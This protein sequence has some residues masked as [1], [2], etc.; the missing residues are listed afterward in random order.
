IWTLSELRRV[1]TRQAARERGLIRYYTGEPC[2]HG[3]VVER[4]VAEPGNCVECGRI[5]NQR[6]RPVRQRY[7]RTP[8][9]KATEFRRSQSPLGRAR[10]A[11]IAHYPKG[12]MSRFRKADHCAAQR[13]ARE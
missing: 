11:R 4:Y 7:A 12:I 2:K 3:H 13:E 6:Q 9:G 5:Q 1:I 10:R 8:K